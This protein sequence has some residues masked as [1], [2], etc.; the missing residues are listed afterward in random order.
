MLEIEKLW[1]RRPIIYTSSG[2]WNA[3]MLTGWPRKAPLWTNEYGLWIAHYTQASQPTLPKGFD[4]WQFWQYTDSD[5][6]EGVAG[7]VDGD[8]FNGTRADFQAYLSGAHAPLK[9]TPTNQQVINLFS[10]AFGLTYWP[11]IVRAGLSSIATK[12]GA[13]YSGKAFS[14]LPLSEA[15]KQKLKSVAGEWWS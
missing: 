15:D 4:H 5:H 2:F 7:H 6:V 11:V 12:R 3:S 13:L 10:K 14:K 1:G 8:R 9:T